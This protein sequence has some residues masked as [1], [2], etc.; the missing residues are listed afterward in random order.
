MSAVKK[1]STTM[2]ITMELRKPKNIKK[3]EHRSM[4]LMRTR[5]RKMTWKRIKRNQE[6]VVDPRTPGERRSKQIKSTRPSIVL[7]DFT[8]CSTWE[9]YI[10]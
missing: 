9:S 7:S 8:T 2:K 6:A 3:K 5:T 10:S 1:K 4:N